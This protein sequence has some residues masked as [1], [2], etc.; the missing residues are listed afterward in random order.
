MKRTGPTNIHLRRLISLLKK[1][2]NKENAP[3]W[4]A[5]ANELSKPTRQRR[6]VN[7]TRIEKH[8]DGKH[9]IVVPGKVLGCGELSKKL[10]IAAWKFSDEAVRK[11][12][13]AEGE[14]ISIQELVKRAPKG[15]GVQI[16][17]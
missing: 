7:L 8:A 15:K 4:D 11:I 2:A 10:T 6:E 17:G 13:A 9:I 16:I 14:V 12:T 5:I 1:I 3:I